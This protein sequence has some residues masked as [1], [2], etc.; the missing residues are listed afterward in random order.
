ME[1][2][3]FWTRPETARKLRTPQPRLQRGRTKGS[4]LATSWL[5]AERSIAARTC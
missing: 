2:D 5:A 1:D 4:G 3:E